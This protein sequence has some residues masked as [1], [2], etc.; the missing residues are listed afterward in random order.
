MSFAYKA[1]QSEAASKN[2]WLRRG[3]SKLGHDERAIL[4]T[5]GTLASCP[6]NRSGTLASRG[7]F[8]QTQ[9]FCC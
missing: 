8:S 5:I 4:P 3:F 6:I 7:Y 2:V 9:Y 1:P